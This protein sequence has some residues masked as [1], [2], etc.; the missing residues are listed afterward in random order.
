MQRTGILH[1]IVFCQPNRIQWI[2]VY[3][4]IC[5]S[6]MVITGAGHN[7]DRA[8]STVDRSSVAKTITGV[9]EIQCLLRCRRA[10]NCKI[11]YY[12]E[13]LDEEASY[14]HFFDKDVTPTIKAMNG[15]EVIMHKQNPGM[16]FVQSQVIYQY[17]SCVFINYFA[18]SSTNLIDV[19]KMYMYTSLYVKR[20]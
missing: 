11:T 4:I 5:H 6:M 14:C 7:Y 19:R 8:L 16:T 9:S 17:T 2:G 15:S 10:A 3:L 13:G 12:E 18:T 1:K 20:I